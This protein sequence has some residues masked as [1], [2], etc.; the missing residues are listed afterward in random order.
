MASGIE[1]FVEHTFAPF[2]DKLNSIIFF[3]I[4]VGGQEFPLI[5]AWLVAGALFF[6][7]YLGFISIRGFP[8]ALRL[9]RGENIA[10]AYQFV[11]SGNADL[12]FVA[13]SQVFNNGILR[14]GSAWLVPT[15]LHAPIRQD[16]VL[17]TRSNKNPA[18]V[19]LLEFLQSQ[20]ATRIIGS[21]GYQVE[22][23]RG[24]GG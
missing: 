20:R 3:G 18:A 15:H 19:A 23:Q 2:A 22:P 1:N 21:F 17:L 6:T 9:V 8:H 16:A 13:R 10:Q 11:S 12:G 4:D 5:V 24:E 7:I 14:S